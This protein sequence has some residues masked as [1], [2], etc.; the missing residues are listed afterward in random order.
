[1]LFLCPLVAHLPLGM[2]RLKENENLSQSC[3][4]GEIYI[5]CCDYR[6]VRI[7][8][9]G[10]EMKTKKTLLFDHLSCYAFSWYLE[11]LISRENSLIWH[12]DHA[13]LSHALL[14]FAEKSHGSGTSNYWHN[15]YCPII[16]F[17]LTFCLSIS[18]RSCKAE[19]IVSVGMTMPQVIAPI[20][21]IPRQDD[22]LPLNRMV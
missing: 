7:S 12:F 3:I 4:S 19:I 6:S 13:M 1:M 8:K 16:L 18:F 14:Y 20:E 21:R 9:K 17:C 11:N 5:S 22:M 10:W 15:F 2:I